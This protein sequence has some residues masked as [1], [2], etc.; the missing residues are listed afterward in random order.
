V[1]N[2]NR[3]DRFFFELAS[4]SRLG[5]LWE[6]ETKKLRMQEIARKLDLTD[7]ETCR[8]LQRLSDSQLIQKQ[9]D[10]TYTITCL[11]AVNLHLIAPIDFANRNSAYFVGHDLS[12][13]PSEFVSRLGELSDAEFCKEAMSGFNRVRKMV[14]EARKYLW[15]V[16]EQVDSSHIQPVTEKVA[17]GLDFKFIMAQNLAK[18]Y[19]NSKDAEVDVLRGSRFM[20]NIPVTLVINESEATVVF[21]TC[22]GVMDY[23]GLFGTSARFRKWCED[24]FMHYWEVSQK[25]YLG[26]QIE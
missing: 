19:S 22:A 23:M 1:E 4:E 14:F 21:R 6:L 26:I 3:L 12:I 25:W 17:K 11:G 5:I 16:A 18:H 13:I 7:T 8:Q 20:K 2:K 24:L 10:G 9:P 15:S